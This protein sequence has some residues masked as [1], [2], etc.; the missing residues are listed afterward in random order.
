MKT[1]KILKETDVGFEELYKLHLNSIIRH[2]YH[3]VNNRQ[4][5]EDIAQETFYL[6][7]VKWEQVS[8]SPAPLRWL[9]QTANYKVMELY[10][11]TSNYP[12]VPIDEAVDV[13]VSEEISHEMS[14]LELIAEDSLTKEE[15]IM[16][17][18]YFLIGYTAEELAKEMGITTNNLRVRLSRAIS[19]LRKNMEI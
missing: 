6:A 12:T 15:W 3:K 18:K 4:I 8:R 19:K 14:E 9:Y 1:N 5:A 11:R 16:V 13:A 7:Y 2:V 17:K 10:R